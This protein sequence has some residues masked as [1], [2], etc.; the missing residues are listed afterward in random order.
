MTDAGASREIRILV[1]DDDTSI[2]CRIRRRLERETGFRICAEAENAAQAVQRALRSHPDICLVGIRLP[3][4]GTAAA[5]EITARS[6][7]T[8]VVMITS[9]T[10]ETELFSALQAGAGSYLVINQSLSRLPQ[11]LRDVHEGK[12]AIPRALVAK[13]VERFHATA[14][15]FRTTDIVGEQG[16]RL[17]S[18]EWDV[19]ELLSSGL[20]TRAIAE[21]LTL[22][23]SGV[24]AHIASIVRKL[25]VRDRAELVAR[26][27]HRS[28]P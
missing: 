14:P 23:P 4:S 17:T 7:R 2:R 28:E 21:R 27:Q 15:R 12:A 16:S 5:W 13:I 22:R 19:L 10:D 1:A 25:G 20:S 11:T 26:F 9:S 8:K 3:G 18:R 24:R 6:P